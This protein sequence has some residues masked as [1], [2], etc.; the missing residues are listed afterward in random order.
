[1]AIMPELGDRPADTVTHLLRVGNVTRDRDQFTGNIPE[2][3]LGS[4]Q[5]LTA[6]CAQNQAASAGSEFTRQRE[7]QAARSA[8]N[9]NHLA[10]NIYPASRS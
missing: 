6:S 7:P 5:F 1:M 4:L 2:M 9:Q 10:L 3:A 8:H